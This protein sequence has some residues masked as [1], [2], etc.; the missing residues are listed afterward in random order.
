VASIVIL[1]AAAVFAAVG[2]GSATSAAP[3]LGGGADVAPANT[4]AFVALD[5]T[6]SSSQRQAL[7]GLLAKFPGYD[8]I[9]GHLEHRFEQKTGLSWADDVT[10]ALGPEVDIAL[11]PSASGG[12]PDAVLLTQPSDPEKLAALLQ[13]ASTSGGPAP[14]SAQVG[15]WTVVG[16]SQAALDAVTGATSH[17]AADPAYENATGRLEHGALVNAYANGAQARQLLSALGH[18]DTSPGKIAWAAGDG[19]AASGGLKL[20]GFIHRDG[21]APQAYRSS[22]VDQIPAGALA[23]ID[24]QADS[25]GDPGAQSGASPVSAALAKLA[26]TLGGETALYVSPGTPLPSLTLVTHP[27]DPEA[28]LAALNEGLATAGKAA[29]GSNTGAFSF[30]SIFGGLQL[31]HSE[32]GDTLVVSTSHE[33]LDAFTGSGTK[34]SG[35]AT[36]EDARQASGMPDQTTGFAYIDLHD[37]LPLVQELAALSGAKAATG[38]P[39]LSALHTLTAYGSGA[40]D[41]VER[42]TAFLGVR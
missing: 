6:M 9:V 28:V 12:K 26:S 21:T 13:K 42:F 29:G 11:L 30:G 4:A 39:D 38:I 15:G 20:D 35:D 16:D 32:V 33:A 24:F 14:A 36:F 25:S 40:S 34:L 1:A 19:V 41:G 18:A 5:T 17:L 37:A 8:T 22:L 23:V 10:P 31:F 3:V 27:A 2:F 7:D